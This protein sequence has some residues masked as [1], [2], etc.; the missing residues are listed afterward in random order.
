[1]KLISLIVAIISVLFVFAACNFETEDLV[2]I[3]FLKAPN[4]T[5]QTGVQ[6]PSAKEF[7]V[8]VVTKTGEMTFT[9][10]NAAL[11]VQGLKDGKLDMTEGSHTLIVI[12]QSLKCEFTY[13]VGNS[14]IKKRVLVTD[15]SLK[16]T[17][18]Q[19]FYN[20]LV[21]TGTT[22]TTVKLTKDIDL[23]KAT[24]GGKEVLIQWVPVVPVSTVVIDGANATTGQPNYTISGLTIENSE[25]KACGLFGIVNQD[26]TVK[27]V[28]FK[29][30]V[31]SS[32]GKQVAVIVGN[33]IDKTLT[34]NNVEI[35][36]VNLFGLSCVAAVCGRTNNLT[37]S[38]VVDGLKITNGTFASFNPVTVATDDGEGD[39]VAA[40]V[41]QLQ[42][43]TT[44]HSI[45]NCN[46]QVNIA[47]T[48]CLGGLVGYVD[49]KAEF[50]NNTITA[51]S[52]I[53]ASVPGGMLMKKGTRN[54]GG[55]IGT[56]AS[57]N[58]TLTNNTV[59][60]NQLYTNNS[61]EASSKGKLIG[62]LRAE[63]V[64]AMKYTI[65]INNGAAL[66]HTGTDTELGV[67]AKPITAENFQKFTAWQ[68]IEI[69]KINV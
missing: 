1:I 69:A 19:N 27:N 20:A 62:G 14:I 2:S 28:I 52:V 67:F 32:V 18:A 64:A 37:T 25:D 59:L 3:T 45:K 58:L 8:K 55:L 35:N 42:S 7:S 36:N 61:Y 26:V 5:Y 53:S 48:R 11:T 43:S 31:I 66:I 68:A 51:D 56:L 4:A 17:D 49:G 30:T 9:L 22:T 23:S 47:G 24:V 54:V 57:G 63:S 15:T 38:V 10:D 39:K 12:Y 6:A 44:G 29:D 34:V 33:M 13:T 50:T 60:T 21:A 40:V 41:G 65:I 46:V 16:G